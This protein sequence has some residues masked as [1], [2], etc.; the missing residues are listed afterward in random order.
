MIRSA[1][2]AL[3]RPRGAPLRT[4]RDAFE[5]QLVTTVMERIDG[6]WK[7]WHLRFPMK[8]GAPGD[9]DGLS[10]PWD[11]V[12]ELLPWIVH[13]VEQSPFTPVGV[14]GT[15][16]SE[17]ILKIGEKVLRGVL[18]AP[19]GGDAER[20]VRNIRRLRD[21]SN[22]LLGGAAQRDDAARRLLVVLDLSLTAFAGLLDEG[23]LDRGFD[24]LNDRDLRAWLRR[25]GLSELAS[26]SALLRSVYDLA[27]AY[28]DGDPGRPR[29]AA[30]AGLRGLLLMFY[31]YRGGFL[32]KMQ[33]G[34]GETVFAPLY[35]ALKK[36]GVRFRFFHRVDE[37]VPD[38]HG[39]GAIRMT[40]QARAP[41]YR[42]LVD[43]KGLPC[44][45]ATPDWDQL[46]E[47][48][49]REDFEAPWHDGEGRA[50]TLRRG[51][52]FDEVVLGIP[53]PALAA[54]TPGLS[55][56][57]ERWAAMVEGLRSVPTRAAQLW[58]SEPLDELGWE[59]QGTIVGGFAEPWDSWADF[60]HL[61]EVEDWKGRRPRS[62]LYLT[63]SMPEAGTVGPAG[64]LRLHSAL[65]AETQAWLDRDARHIWPGAVSR[66]G[67]RSELYV[68]TR[69]RRGRLQSQYVRIN[70]RPSERYVQGHPG[71]TQ[72]RLPADAPDFDN[73]FLA[74]DWV[75]TGLDL[76]CL[77]CATMAGRQAARAILG[78]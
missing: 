69:G 10:A 20:A 55:A 7:P 76:G 71:T 3:D 73:L 42:P 4:W 53:Q 8:P 77:E 49:P 1:Y 59:L 18:D 64:E 34:M 63:A 36:R 72:L 40:R 44:W 70:T 13:Q 66:T 47:G 46:P 29:L 51:S 56:R 52:H 6:Q 25:Q 54:L 43:V 32:W 27:F 60:S 61:V 2:E 15:K 35:L 65:T 5:P 22:R 41:G 39:I 26:G 30:G 19:R 14:G 67:F 21:F 17:R 57:S 9:Q 16:L 38:E 31:G 48:T 50:V 12:S 37:L 62:C 78:R 11:L 23:V 45:P 24:H 58:L 74:G 28:E 33:A 75:K 68:S